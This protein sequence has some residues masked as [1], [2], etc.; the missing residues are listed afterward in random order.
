MTNITKEFTYNLA[1]DQYYQTNDNLLVGV[2]TYNG[3]SIFRIVEI[4]RQC[5]ITHMS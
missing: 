2:Q 5:Q 1:D 4:I 3:P